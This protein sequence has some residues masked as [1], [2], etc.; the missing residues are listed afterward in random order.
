MLIGSRPYTAE[1]LELL[2]ARHLSAPTPRL[3]EEHEALQP[4]LDRLMAKRPQDR[5]PSARALLDDLAQRFLPGVP[6]GDAR[7]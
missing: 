5:Y 6:A 4:V 7:A 1:T 2:L 3:P